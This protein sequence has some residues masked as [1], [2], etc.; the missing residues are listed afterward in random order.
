MMPMRSFLIIALAVGFMLPAKAQNV[1]T[2]NLKDGSQL[3]GYMK[4]QKP[5][6]NC[7]FYAEN[8]EVLIDRQKVKN[9]SSQKVDYNNLP[10]AWKK[11]ADENGLLD[12][13]KEVT[14][15]SIDTG[16]VINN[17]RILEEGLTVKYIELNHDYT[18]QW[19]DIASIEYVQRDVLQLSGVNH[20]LK[21]K[22][23]GLVRM[24]TGQIIK[25]I[26]GD[27]TVVLKDDGVKV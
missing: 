4:S 15:S 1:Q 22:E 23:D 21:V 14:L 18:L 2:L 3:H 26:P 25:K 19:K 27:M 9:I 20:N 16:A 5:G 11:Y 12:K 6:S 13:K 8:A 17:V 24:V 10:E 7:I